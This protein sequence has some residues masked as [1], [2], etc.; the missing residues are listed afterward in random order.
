MGGGSGRTYSG[1][2]EIKNQSGLG[3]RETIKPSFKEK[4][5]V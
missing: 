5:E 2:F 1:V 3:N 4:E